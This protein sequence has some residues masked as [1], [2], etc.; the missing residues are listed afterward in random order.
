M[1]SLHAELSCRQDRFGSS[2][3]IKSIS[4]ASE[5]ALKQ[6]P[7]DRKYWYVS[8]RGLRH[9]GHCPILELDSISGTTAMDSGGRSD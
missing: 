1:Q 4:S 7:K 9:S 8:Y 5:I 6:I 3:D 2:T